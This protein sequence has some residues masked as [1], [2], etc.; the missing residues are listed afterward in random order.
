MLTDIIINHVR[1][2][3]WQVCGFGCYLW[4][5]RGPGRKRVDPH[6]LTLGMGSCLGQ[7]YTCSFDLWRIFYLWRWTLWKRKQWLLAA[8]SRLYNFD[9]LIYCV[10]IWLYLNND[11]KESLIYFLAEKQQLLHVIAVAFDHYLEWF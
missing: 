7:L 11:Y 9:P 2:S 8:L 4:W 3:S 6:L 10:F 5:S 1:P